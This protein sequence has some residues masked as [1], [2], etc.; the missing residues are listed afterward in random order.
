MGASSSQWNEYLYAAGRVVA[1]HF[2]F[3]DGS[4]ILRYFIADHLGSTSVLTDEGGALAERDSYDA[5]GKRRNADGSD[6][7]GLVSQTTRGFTGQEH[8]PTVGLINYNARAYDPVVGRFISADTMVASAFSG[9]NYNRFSYVVNNPLTLVDPT[10]HDQG[11]PCFTCIK[12]DAGGYSY[13]YIDDEGHETVVIVAFVFTSVEIVGGGGPGQGSSPSEGG[14]VV[15]MAATSKTNL[16]SPT[17]VPNAA[18]M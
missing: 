5:W 1:A 10:G 12:R 6:D 11:I 7:S 14:V 9:Q 8:M 15:A 17:R 13:S 18:M 4:T 3:S 2:A 16:S